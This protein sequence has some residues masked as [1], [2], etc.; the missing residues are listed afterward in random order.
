MEKQCLHLMLMNL[1][2]HNHQGQ[3]VN[4]SQDVVLVIDHSGSMDSAVTAKNENGDNLENGLSIQDIVNHAARTVANTLDKNSRLGVVIF[5]NRIE[6]LFNLMLMTEDSSTACAKISTIKPSGQTNIWDALKSAIQMLND[7][8]DKTRNGHIMMLTDDFNISPSRG[9]I[10]TLKRL[11]K[12]INFTAQFI[13]LVLVIIFN[14]A[15][16]MILQNTA[17]GG[18]GHI[19]DGG[20]IA[21]VFCNFLGTIMATVVLNL[22]LHITYS[23]DVYFAEI[24]PV[25]GDF[26]Y[27]IDTSDSS[28][29]TVIVDIGTVQVGQMRNIIMNT[30]HLTNP[31]SYFYTYKI[32]GQSFTSDKVLDVYLSNCHLNEQQ[33]NIHNSRCNT[34]E[35]LCKII[36]YKPLD[37]MMRLKHVIM[38]LKNILLPLTCKIPF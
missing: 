33:V 30:H 8:E 5:N 16:F 34:V 13:H 28:N 2:C 17:N 21:T 4:L 26:A 31:F 9:E 19:P 12:S 38:N 29:R 27:H 22:Q 24:H 23:E 11:R 25:M 3:P 6:T 1:L 18:N 14:V 7:R 15:Y 20:M 32:A 36:N 10:E 35:M 37:K